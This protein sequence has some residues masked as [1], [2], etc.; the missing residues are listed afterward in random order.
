MR[1]IHRTLMDYRPPLEL[2]LL[3]D[4][5]ASPSARPVWLS[6]SSADLDHEDRARKSITSLSARQK[7][8]A[9]VKLLSPE[10]ELMNLTTP[11][12]FLC[13]GP[14]GQSAPSM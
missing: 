10:E 6:D 4:N 8:K 9:L 11:T 12:G 14:P 2:S 13:T 1:D 7:E 3:L 5:M